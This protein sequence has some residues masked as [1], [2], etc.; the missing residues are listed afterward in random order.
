MAWQ[1]PTVWVG[2]SL[3]PIVGGVALASLTEASFNWYV[4]ITIIG[5]Q[6]YLNLTIEDKSFCQMP[7]VL[8]VSLCFSFILYVGVHGHNYGYSLTDVFSFS[9]FRTKL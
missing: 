4:T 6:V 7:Y 2:L 8:F 9:M 3:L 5:M 1:L